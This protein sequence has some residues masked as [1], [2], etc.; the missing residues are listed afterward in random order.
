MTLTKKIQT[1]NLEEDIFLAG[2]VDQPINLI[3]EADNFILSSQFEGFGLVIVE[4]LAAGI[5]VVSTDC[6]SGPA[7]ILGNGL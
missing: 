6:Q 7:E 1:L 5:T 3:K 4:A 2:S